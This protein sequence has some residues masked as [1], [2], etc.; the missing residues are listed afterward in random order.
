MQDGHVFPQRVAG[1]EGD[2]L[3]GYVLVVQLSGQRVAER[4][5]ADAL[6]EAQGLH[7]A[8]ELVH[9]ALAVARIRLTGLP[10]DACREV[11]EEAR[12]PAS[13]DVLQEV[14]EAD[15]EE[16]LGDGNPPHF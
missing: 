8:A 3:V 4:M 11:G 15:I 13:L 14:Q 9:R 10:V 7:V 5:S 6:S 2:V 12:V 1:D 16:W